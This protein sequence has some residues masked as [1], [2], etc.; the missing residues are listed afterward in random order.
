VLDYQFPLFIFHSKQKEKE[1][2]AG[3]GKGVEDSCIT[4]HLIC[5]LTKT[6]RKTIDIH[7]SFP[8]MVRK[9]TAR[10][11]TSEGCGRG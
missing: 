11:K 9:D 2:W 8:D 1:T 5:D 7:F 6:A 10:K 4:V 3:W